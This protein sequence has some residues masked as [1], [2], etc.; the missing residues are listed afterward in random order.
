MPMSGGRREGGSFPV[1][2]LAPLVAVLAGD[3]IALQA[4]DIAAQIAGTA[5][6]S[7]RTGSRW[8]RWVKL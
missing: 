7:G 5:L 2:A 6:G 3:G 8:A 4:L 1:I